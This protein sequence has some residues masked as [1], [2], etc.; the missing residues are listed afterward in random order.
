MITHSS[1]LSFLLYQSFTDKFFYRI[2]FDIDI[3]IISD[4]LQSND[5][6]YR[7]FFFIR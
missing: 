4:V 1:C 3:I 5:I 7:K 6:K 2:T